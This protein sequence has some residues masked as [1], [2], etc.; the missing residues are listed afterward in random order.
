MKTDESISLL[1]EKLDAW[2]DRLLPLLESN[3]TAAQS[4]AL[5]EGVGILKE[6]DRLKEDGIAV[7]NALINQQ[8]SAD[9]RVA[10]LVQGFAFGAQLLGA[11]YELGDT[12]GGNKVADR[13]REVV[14]KL[15]AIEPGGLS[16]AALLDHPDDVV[17]VYAGQYLIDRMAER[18]VPVLRSIDEKNDGS[19]A[20]IRAMTIL[21]PRDWDQKEK[22]RGT[23]KK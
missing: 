10:S 11:L 19:H 9:G 1:A 23:R 8:D 3:D 12:D 7:L 18:V 16:L 2:V 21:F 13:V 5:A 14:R 15:D 4:K 17:R 22:E 6:L 20:T